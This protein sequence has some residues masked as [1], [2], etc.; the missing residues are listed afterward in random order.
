MVVHFSMDGKYLY[1]DSNEA[2]EQEEFIESK[3]T[4][5]KILI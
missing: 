5:A 2:R 4:E 3:K 1:Q